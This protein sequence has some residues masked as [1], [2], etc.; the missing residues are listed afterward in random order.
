M[1][2][3]TKYP[4]RLTLATATVVFPLKQLEESWR[5]QVNSWSLPP[6]KDSLCKL[7]NPHYFDLGWS[8]K[9]GRLFQWLEPARNS[10]ESLP[11]IIGGKWV[12]RL[13]AALCGTLLPR[14]RLLLLHTQPAE[15]KPFLPEQRQDS[16]SLILKTL[17]QSKEWLLPRISA[18]SQ[19]TYKSVFLSLPKKCLWF[20]G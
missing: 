4:V 7:I 13:A 16:E 1:T 5:K 3:G 8:G 17:W 10:G 18:T 14:W 2:D 12:L 9:K 19:I 15:P 20:L 11:L 6:W